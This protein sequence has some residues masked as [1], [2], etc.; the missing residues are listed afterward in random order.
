MMYCSF[1]DFILYAFRD[2]Q[3][4]CRVNQQVKEERQLAGCQTRLYVAPVAFEMY[5][6]IFTMTAHWIEI[7]GGALTTECMPPH[8]ILGALPM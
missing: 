4:T 5:E 1:V 8:R 6:G 2:I 3:F 7:W